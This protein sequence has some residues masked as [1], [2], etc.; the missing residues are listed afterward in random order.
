[1]RSPK[2][3]PWQPM[4]LCNLNK[5]DEIRLHRSI[6]DLVMTYKKKISWRIRG[7]R[8]HAPRR[9]GSEQQ[10]ASEGKAFPFFNKTSNCH[11]LTFTVCIFVRARFYAGNFPYRAWHIGP[12][13]GWRRRGRLRHHLAVESVAVPDFRGDFCVFDVLWRVI[14]PIKLPEPLDNSF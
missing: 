9:K 10:S 3:V 2:R 4:S 5:N 1:M 8:G 14:F 13:R 12:F 11:N 7:F 6:K